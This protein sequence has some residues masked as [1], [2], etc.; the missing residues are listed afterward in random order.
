MAKVF[1]DYPQALRNT[2]AIAERC[3][4]DLSGTVHRLPNFDVPPPFESPEDYF[5]QRGEAR[6]SR[7]GCRA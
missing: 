1:G 3:D 5:R 4:V 7:T 6:A 2:V